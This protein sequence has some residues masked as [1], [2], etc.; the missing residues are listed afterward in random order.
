MPVR[1]TLLLTV[2]AFVLVALV[3]FYTSTVATRR[4]IG[5]DGN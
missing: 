5:T 1:D 2:L 3:S 4:G